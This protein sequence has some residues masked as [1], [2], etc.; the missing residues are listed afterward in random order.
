MSPKRLCTICARSG[1]KGVKHKNIK[2]FCGKPLIAHTIIQAQKSGLFDA[3]AV[4]SD[5]DYFLEIAQEFGVEYRVLRPAHLASDE[6][7]KLPTIRHCTQEVEMA[8][9]YLFDTIIDLAV[10]SP[11]R[12]TEDIYGVVELLERCIT[13]NT[14]LSGHK[15]K[16]SP[17]FNLVEKDQHNFIHISKKL[18]SEIIRRQDSPRCY[19]L[20]G[21]AYGFKRKALFNTEQPLINAATMLYEMP[22]I[23]SLDIDDSLDFEIAGF[24]VGKNI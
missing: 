6:A 20:N 18:N 24:L 11:L 17:Y 13:T 2:L 12:A 19:E 8:T 14:V 5:S 9:N 4:S 3:I 22:T 16:S 1:S 15:T 7:A 23:R 10:T 21:A